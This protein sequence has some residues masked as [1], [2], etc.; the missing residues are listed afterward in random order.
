M[1]EARKITRAFDFP[2]TAFPGDETKGV[3]LT[4]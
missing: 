3:P 2:S 1:F 4:L